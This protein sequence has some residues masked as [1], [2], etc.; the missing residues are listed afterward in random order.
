MH[1]NIKNRT[2]IKNFQYKIG[3]EIYIIVKKDTNII[4]VVICKLKIIESCNVNDEEC[5]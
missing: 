1:F 5:G 3:S 2:I 4:S